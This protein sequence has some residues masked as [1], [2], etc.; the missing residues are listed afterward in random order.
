MSSSILL[1][2]FNRLFIVAYIKSIKYIFYIYKYMFVFIKYK[3][4]KESEAHIKGWRQSQ[5]LTFT[6]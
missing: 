5:P 6:C 3:Y 2:G 1:G 4:K